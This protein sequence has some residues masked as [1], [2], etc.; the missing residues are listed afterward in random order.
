MTDAEIE[1]ARAEAVPIQ[2]GWDDAFR[3]VDVV[4]S[5]TIPVLPPTIDDM[6]VM[7]GG[8]ET[9]ADL[10]FISWNCAMNI[11]GIPSLSLP[12]GE[13]S[14]LPIGMTITGPKGADDLVLAV[15]AAMESALDDAFVDRIVPIS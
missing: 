14:G 13:L 15:G 4:V 8:E 5:P 9:H 2:R 12:C 11:A 1:A 7:V 10:A 3:A 6:K